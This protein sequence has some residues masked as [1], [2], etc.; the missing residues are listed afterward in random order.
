MSHL[1]LAGSIVSHDGSVVRAGTE[2]LSIGYASLTGVANIKGKLP[3][4]FLIPGVGA[5]L[6]KGGGSGKSTF[7]KNLNCKIIKHGERDVSNKDNDAKSKVIIA[8]TAAQMVVALF[9]EINAG[10]PCIVIDS[11]MRYMTGGGA[12]AAGGF[13]YELG[14]MM[15]D[16]GSI[17]RDTG[18]TVIIVLNARRDGSTTDDI[19][20]R[21]VGD[22]ASNSNFVIRMDS[23]DHVSV[24]YAHSD[25]INGVPREM[26][27]YEYQIDTSTLSLVRA[28]TG[29]T[30]KTD[31]DGLVDLNMKR[32]R[33]LRIVDNPGDVLIR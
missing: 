27:P 2:V 18:Q 4:D 3:H 9:A 10:T 7:V 33:N 1:L 6:S 29:V 8:K 14:Y 20:E 16:L 12:L 24:K 13:N 19:Y 30:E 22:A 25:S 21:V 11:M 32:K 23:Y 28:S 17:L 26:R 5:L 15:A 31:S